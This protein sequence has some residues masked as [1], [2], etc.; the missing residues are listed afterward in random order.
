VKVAG[1]YEIDVTSSAPV[2]AWLALLVERFE[3]FI[4]SVRAECG[5]PAGLR[6]SRPV[7]PSP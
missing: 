2:F 1:K 6:A 4:L 7:S 5:V 3:P